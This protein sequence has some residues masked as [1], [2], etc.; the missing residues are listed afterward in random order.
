MRPVLAWKAGLASMTSMRRPSPW[1][2]HVGA[3]APRSIQ[4]PIASLGTTSSCP[5][6][7]L[8]SPHMMLGTCPLDWASSRALP[9]MAEVIL[10]LIS[11]SWLRQ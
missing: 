4:P 1:L 2:R 10:L 11:E 3:G 6:C 7:W 8:R 5:R 9:T